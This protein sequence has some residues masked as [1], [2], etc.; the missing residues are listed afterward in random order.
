MAIIAV[1]FAKY[2]TRKKVDKNLDSISKE[3][4]K[5]AECGNTFIEVKQELSG[6]E[7]ARLRELGYVVK[8]FYEMYKKRTFIHWD[9]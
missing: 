6:V 8:Q 3:I 2:C 9:L 1:D 5:Q 4:F 7:I